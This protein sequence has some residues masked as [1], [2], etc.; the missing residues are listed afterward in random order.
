M[1]RLFIALIIIRLFNA[2][3]YHIS[4][5]MI[6]REIRKYQNI[7]LHLNTELIKEM[8]LS[9]KPD[10]VI[11]ASGA[12]PVIPKVPGIDSPKVVLAEDVLREPVLGFNPRQGVTKADVIAILE[13]AL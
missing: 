8:V 3:E 10:K 9:G 12:K 6:F 4:V 7:T 13:Q 1:S 11:I 5:L 2:F